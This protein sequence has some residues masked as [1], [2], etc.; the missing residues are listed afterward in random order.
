VAII[1]EYYVSGEIYTFEDD[2]LLNMWETL[3]DQVE[4]QKKEMGIIEMVLQRRMQENNAK[5]L[6][7]TTLEVALG[8]PGYDPNVLRTLGEHIPPEIFKR[9]FAP[10]HEEKVV[11][12]VPDKFDMRTVGSW[13]SYGQHIVD[14]ITNAEIPDSRRISIKH[15]KGGQNAL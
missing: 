6:M 8:A 11:K 12:Q 3:A 9:G 5:K 10:A 14:I 7:S 15:K 1:G 2:I 4:K 13:K